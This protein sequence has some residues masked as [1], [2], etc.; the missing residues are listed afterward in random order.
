MTCAR[1]TL[2]RKHKLLPSHISPRGSYKLS[3]A[4]SA[5]LIPIFNFATLLCDT[6]AACRTLSPEQ[7]CSH[8][9]TLWPRPADQCTP[10]HLQPP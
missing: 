1:V 7:F 10:T 4:A 8:V 3:L 9:R 2:H 6:K 5:C